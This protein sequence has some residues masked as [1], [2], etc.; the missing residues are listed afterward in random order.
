MYS[1]LLVLLE[2][3]S[4]LRRGRYYHRIWDAFWGKSGFA[5]AAKAGI[6]DMLRS[7]TSIFLVLAVS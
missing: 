2:D 4:L 5:A 7:D 6:I 3:R 1:M